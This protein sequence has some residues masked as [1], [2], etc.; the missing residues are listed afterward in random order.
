MPLYVYDTIRTL[1]AIQL[2]VSRGYDRWTGGRV[3]YDRAEGL[4]D[5]FEKL[6]TANPSRAQDMRLRRAGHARSRLVLLP[7]LQALQ[8]SWW[9]LVSEGA[10]PVTELEKLL[11]ATDRRQRVTL[12]EW[13]L[14]RLPKREMKEAAA[15]SWRLPE[16]KFR[17]QWAHACAVATHESPRQAQ[18]LIAA[19]ATWPG[20]HGISQQRHDL[21]QAMVEARR[22]AGRR[23]PLELPP[24]PPWPRLLKLKGHGV[25]LAVAA[26]RMRLAVLETALT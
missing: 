16:K 23:D 4:V 9:L 25:P 21:Q 15:W 24:H 26:E 1:Q 22:G 7:D 3:R 2:Y 8:F 6:Y 10:G 19:M 14:L 12:Q 11:D 18:A 20:F 13:E 5:K 17:E